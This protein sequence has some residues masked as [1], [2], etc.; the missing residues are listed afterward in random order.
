MDN[1]KARSNAFFPGE[2]ECSSVAA[3]SRP[4]A[5][6]GAVGELAGDVR[7]TKQPTATM[8]VDDRDEA[9]ASDAGKQRGS[10]ARRLGCGGSTVTAQSRARRLAPVLL[11]EQIT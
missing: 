3:L 5:A 4:T 10:T 2:P 9:W 1:N 11:P 7:P 8:V 6:G